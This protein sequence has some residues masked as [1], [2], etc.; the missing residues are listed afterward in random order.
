MYTGVYPKGDDTYNIE[1]IVPATVFLTNRPKGDIV[2][3]DKEPYHDP[4]I[5][6]PA[7]KDINTIRANYVFGEIKPSS[8]ARSRT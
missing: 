2:E 8:L 4:H 7:L 5:L 6:F 1:H 3:L